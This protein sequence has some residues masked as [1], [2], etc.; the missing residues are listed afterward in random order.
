M[1]PPPPRLPAAGCVTASAKA[2]ATAASTAFPPFFRIASPASDAMGSTDTTAPLANESGPACGFARSH[3]HNIAESR[4][5]N[6]ERVR[7]FLIARDYTLAS[8][9]VDA[10]DQNCLRPGPVEKQ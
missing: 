10:P 8:A 6:A 7:V 3:E 5:R 9:R 2:V 4:R 1:Y